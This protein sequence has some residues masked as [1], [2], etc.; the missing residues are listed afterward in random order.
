M[1]M[2]DAIH[3][4]RHVSLHGLYRPPSHMHLTLQSILSLSEQLHTFVPPTRACLLKGVRYRREGPVPM[5]GS[6][7]EKAFGFPSA[8]SFYAFI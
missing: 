5:K 3:S 6:G 2:A 1:A 8:E 7:I 4:R